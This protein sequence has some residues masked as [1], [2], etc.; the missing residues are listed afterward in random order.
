M[1]ELPLQMVEEG[2]AQHGGTAGVDKLYEAKTHQR[3]TLRGRPEDIL[4][5]GN[6]NCAGERAPAAP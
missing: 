3:T 2:K 6:Q 5:P 1:P 4:V